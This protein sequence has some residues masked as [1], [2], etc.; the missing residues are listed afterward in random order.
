LCPTSKRLARNCASTAFGGTPGRKTTVT[1]RET[2]VEVDLLPGGGAVD[3]G[4][5][6]IPSP[7]EVSGEPQILPLDRL[8][9][10]KLSTYIARGIARAK[11]YADVVE[12]MKAND[13][14]R[15]YPVDPAVRDLYQKM[16]DEL[17][18]SE[19]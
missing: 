5:V 13:L 7:A 6:R 9:S 3:P 18:S 12:L 8:I 16:W 15:D 4:P 11:D 19:A 2:R 17:R 14:P 10:S 1:D